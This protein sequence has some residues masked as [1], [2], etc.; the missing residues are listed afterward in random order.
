MYLSR[1]KYNK[2]QQKRISHCYETKNITELY[3]FLLSLPAVVHEFELL[4][5]TL[6]RILLRFHLSLR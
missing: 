3:R 4:R 5:V 1:V 2:Q 6:Y